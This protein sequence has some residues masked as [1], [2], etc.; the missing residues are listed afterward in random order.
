M[1]ITKASRLSIFNQLIKADPQS[2]EYWEKALDDSSPTAQTMETMFLNRNDFQREQAKLNQEK[3][4]LQAEK[5]QLNTWKQSQEAHIS[6]ILTQAQQQV[7]QAALMAKTPLEKL[8]AAKAKADRGEVLTYEDLQVDSSVQAFAQTHAPQAQ[9]QGMNQFAQSN[10]GH[11]A[12]PS[13]AVSNLQAP[14]Q[15]AQSAQQQ[16]SPEQFAQLLVDEVT[17]LRKIELDHYKLFGEWMDTPTIV[18]MARKDGRSLLDVYNE[19]YNP[20]AKRQEVE[21]ALFNAKVEEAAKAKISE[22]LSSQDPSGKSNSLAD[23]GM[24][25]STN[26]QS[27]SPALKYSGPEFT[28]ANMDPLFATTQGMAQQQNLALL[29]Q[30]PQ[31]QSSTATP[32]PSQQP[33]E[34]LGHMNEWLADMRQG[35]MDGR[36]AKNPNLQLA[37]V[38]GLGL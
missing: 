22:I 12:A 8:Q 13:Q 5:Q 7:A 37:S 14:V 38:P 4:A 2:K 30:Q 18:N 17:Q 3:A 11:F 25:T 28:A 10:L 19:T 21:T 15:P 33:V 26:P 29:Q 24:L 36:A 23:F 32:P 34:F 1:P 9:A 16:M 35:V 6:T 20:E 27:G 31:A